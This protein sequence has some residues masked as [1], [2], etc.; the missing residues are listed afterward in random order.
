MTAGHAAFV[1]LGPRQLQNAFFGNHTMLAELAS[2]TFFLE[3]GGYIFAAESFCGQ[4]SEAFSMFLNSKNF[5]T[6]Q[7]LQFS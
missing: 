1:D 3:V 4:V 6:S 7:G 5:S 2:V